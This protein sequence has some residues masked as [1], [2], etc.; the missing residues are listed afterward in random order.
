MR[1]GLELPVHPV[2]DNCIDGVVDALD[3][4]G[5]NKPWLEHIL[6]RVDPNNKMRCVTILRPR[7]LHCVESAEAGVTGRGED[8]VCTFADL[9][10]RDFFALAG[11]VP[12]GIGDTNIV[13]NYANVGIDGARAFLVATLEPVN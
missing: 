6:I 7:L 8:H 11:I 10:Q 2:L 9:R 4:T 12:G 1:T 3:H 13:W 5:E